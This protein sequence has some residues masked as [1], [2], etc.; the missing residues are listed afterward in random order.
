MRGMA[1]FIL[2]YVALGAQ[3]GLAPYL[4]IGAP[5]NLVLPAV[6]FIAL[7]APKEPAL[8]GCFGLGL[9]QDML[10]QQSL[11]VYALSYGLIGIFVIGTQNL[12]YRDHPLTH[13]IVAFIGSIICSILLIAHDVVRYRGLEA[14]R[15]IAISKLLYMTLYTTIVAPLVLWILQRMRRSFRFQKRR[16]AV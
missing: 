12:L 6:I 3:V 7:N 15:R 10:T 9:M 4:R 13:V 1:Y 2:A 5:P 16:A 11:G 14:D 8:L